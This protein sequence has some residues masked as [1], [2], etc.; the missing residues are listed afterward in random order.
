MPRD[1]EF[2]RRAKTRQ[3]TDKNTIIYFIGAID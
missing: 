3:T 2:V 1:A